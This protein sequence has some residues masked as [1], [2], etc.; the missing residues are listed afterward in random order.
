MAEAKPTL[1]ESIIQRPAGHTTIEIEGREYVFKPR[2]EAG[3]AAHVAP[4]SVPAHIQR[5]LSISEG[6]RLYLGDEAYAQATL[7]D[8]RLGVATPRSA[9][10]LA[11]ADLPDSRLGVESP[12]T[13]PSLAVAAT[14][15]ADLG[16]TDDDDDDQD[17]D[18]DPD[19][20][21]GADLDAEP[22]AETDEGIDPDIAAMDFDQMIAVFTKLNG[23]KPPRANI[24]KATLYTKLAE[25]M[26]AEQ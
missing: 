20:S 5:L 2:P 15:D 19:T 21:A 23:G 8:A 14:T 16:V 13:V 17:D 24:T 18:E 22:D 12:M 7:P 25:M 10:S 1:I 4:V 3:I 6:Y 26:A 9:P 11:A